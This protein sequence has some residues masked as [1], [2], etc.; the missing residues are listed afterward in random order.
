MVS[1]SKVSILIAAMLILVVMVS[2]VAAVEKAEPPKGEDQQAA[3]AKAIPTISEW[4]MIIFS[5]LLIGWMAYTIVQRKRRAT[6]D[7]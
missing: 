2:G 3:Q 7:F 4:G 6:S 1:K 5:V